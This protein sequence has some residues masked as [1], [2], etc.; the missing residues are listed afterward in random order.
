LIVVVLRVIDGSLLARE[1]TLERLECRNVVG[2]L[3]G[4]L[5]TLLYGSFSLLVLCLRRLQA[6]LS[7]GKLRTRLL[8]SLRA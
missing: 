2:G 1:L 5:L 7:E 6:G 4:L 3:L 8:R